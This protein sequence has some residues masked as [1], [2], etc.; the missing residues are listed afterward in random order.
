[1]VGEKS[2]VLLPIVGCCLFF[3]SYLTT[4]LAT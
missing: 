3:V 2:A 4:L 1:V